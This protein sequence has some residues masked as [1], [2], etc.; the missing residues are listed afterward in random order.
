M[1]TALSEYFS[2]KENDAKNDQR[3]KELQIVIKAYMEAHEVERV[4]DGRGYFV[5][6]KLLQR[7]KYDAD[8]V[9]DIL[10]SANLETKWQAILS[11]DD[12]KLKAILKSLPSP[13]REEIE[14]SKILQ[15][16]YTVLSASSKPSKK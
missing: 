7:F 5:A 12:K 9:H 2:I 15:R 14:K 6:K 13:V 1:Q 10:L 4:F 8:A 16:E 3:S 11:A